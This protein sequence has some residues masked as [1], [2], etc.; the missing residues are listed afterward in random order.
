[1]KGNRIEDKGWE[2][3]LQVSRQKNYQYMFLYYIGGYI[4]ENNKYDKVLIFKINKHINN[5]KIMNGLS[6]KKS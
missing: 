6:L 3:D 4:F 2:S 5:S 1:M